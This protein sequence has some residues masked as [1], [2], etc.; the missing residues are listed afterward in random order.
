MKAL[1]LAWQDPQTR[2][3]FPVGKLTFEDG[4]Y[5][6]VYT[7]GAKASPKFIPF[8]LMRDL[9]AVYKSKELFPLFANRLLSR[10][11]PEYNRILKW[12]DLRQ[13]EADPLVLLARTEGIRETDSLTVFS[14]PEPNSEGN[15]QVQFFSHGLGYLPDQA[16]KRINNLAIGERLFVML[17]PQ[18][19]YDRFAI[20]LRT[21]DP[22]T[23]VG[24]CPRYVSHDFLEVLG[25]NLD[26][27]RVSV[28]RV[29]VD[30]PIQLR[31]LCTLTAEWPANF[32]PCSSE[33]YGELAS[34]VGHPSS[35]S[36]I[37]TLT[38]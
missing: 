32:E 16:V 12:G 7:K 36:D 8:G 4:H 34:D 19:P 23:I 28:K 9:T 22:A 3:W 18:N 11:R 26:S 13:D 33:Y 21:D 31:L 24:Y 25:N 5:R 29:N 17:D 37:G 2:G 14:C 6:F 38:H 20:A 35:Y 30:A 27:V 10:K 15:Y 1:F